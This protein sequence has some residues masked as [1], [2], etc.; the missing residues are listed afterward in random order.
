MPET[1]LSL[2]QTIARLDE[3]LKSVQD[4]IKDDWDPI[5]LGLN[6]AKLEYGNL[7]VPV[8]L[9]TFDQLVK[10]IVERFPRDVS[11]KER[12][13]YLLT[14]FTE[15]LGFK[16]DTNNYYNVKNSFLND[17]FLRRKGIPISLSLVFMGLVKR[18]GMKSVG[19]SFPG[20]FLVR[21]IPQSLDEEKEIESSGPWFV[22]TFEEGK[23]LTLEDCQDRLNSW[24]RG[25]IPFS[26]EVLKTAH[27]RDIVSR[28][29]RNLRA[30]YSEKEDLPRLYWVLTSLVQLCPSD[31]LESLKE[32]G[33]L[34]ARMGRFRAAIED[35]R[36][37]M[38]TSNSTQNMD[39]I[40]KMLRYFELQKEL[41]N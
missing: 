33:F 21:L 4:P 2:D 29:L 31:H 9:S 15:V 27:P 24:T 10:A 23:I 14:S 40:E 18:V 6:L 34:F 41:T 30:I 12:T 28:M 35:L 25:M 36:L 1:K 39:H 8:E 26:P 20:H 16:G 3:L 13:A 7:N 38:R 19:I 32:R 11:L 22:D 5:E 37:F 17:V